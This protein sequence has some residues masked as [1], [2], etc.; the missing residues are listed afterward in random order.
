[1]EVRIGLERAFDRAIESRGTGGTSATAKRARAAEGRGGGAEGTS[2][3]VQSTR[4]TTFTRGLL[5][6]LTQLGRATSR[7]E[8]WAGSTRASTQGNRPD[9]GE[10]AHALPCS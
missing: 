7:F 9:V 5:R 1:P 2:A 3:G 4:G 6:G 8:L 10:G